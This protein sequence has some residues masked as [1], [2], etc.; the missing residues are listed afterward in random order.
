MLGAACEGPAPAPASAQ[1]EQGR[2]HVGLR[3]AAV[4]AHTGH[5]ACRTRETAALMPA[6][7]LGRA[8][9]GPLHLAGSGCSWKMP[10]E[11]GFDLAGHWW[12]VGPVP[13][14]TVGVHI[15]M[16][17]RGQQALQTYMN[18][19]SDGEGLPLLIRCSTVMSYSVTETSISRCRYTLV[20]L[21]PGTHWSEH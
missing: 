15:W 13:D 20:T 8:W 14:C 1:I 16:A 2:H 9:D 11:R 6:A 17:G 7:A 12:P 3:V 19:S 5:G 10:Q 21:H 18:N 4:L